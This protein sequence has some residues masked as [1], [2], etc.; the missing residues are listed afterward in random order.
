GYWNNRSAITYGFPVKAIK[1]NVNL[2]TGMDYVITPGLINGNKNLSNT[3]NFNG[4]ITI[5]SNINERIDFTIA[6]AGNYSIVENTIQAQL[7]NNYYYHIT[8]TRINWLP[9]EKLVLNTELY[10]TAYRG[11]GDAFNQDIVLWNAAVGYKFL[12]KNAGE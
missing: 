4:G 12:K 3:L 7:N 2:S 10:Y 1:S 8:S 9:V 5:G 11:L 6:Y